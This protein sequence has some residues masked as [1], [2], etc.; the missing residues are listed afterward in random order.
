[1][2]IT[3]KSGKIMERGR[4]S[5]TVAPRV[6][7]PLMKCHLSKEYLMSGE[8]SSLQRIS[9]EQGN[10]IAHTHTHTLLVKSPIGYMCIFVLCMLVHMHLHVYVYHNCSWAI[11]YFL[12]IKH[13]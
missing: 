13:A 2:Q 1:M 6:I 8:G 9:D 3:S 7:P 5:E 12:I 10:F 4:E 11:N